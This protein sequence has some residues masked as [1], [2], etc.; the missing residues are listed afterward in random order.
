MAGS[1]LPIPR[2]DSLVAPRSCVA[3][4]LRGAYSYGAA[5]Q[6]PGVVVVVR[7]CGVVVTDIYDAICLSGPKACTC[8][9]NA[10]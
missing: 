1:F 2:R 3:S 9:T 5:S 4:H 7:R 10:K 8:F 6:A